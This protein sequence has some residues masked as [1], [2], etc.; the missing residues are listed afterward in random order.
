MKTLRYLFLSALC[1]ALPL[2]AQDLV[3]KVGWLPYWGG[4]D[5]VTV[6]GDNAYVINDYGLLSFD[7]S[8]PANPEMIGQFYIEESHYN[9]RGMQVVGEV[10]NVYMDEFF[11]FD[12]SDPTNPR[13]L[14]A[15]EPNFGAIQ[16][17]NYI[18]SIGSNTIRI[19]DVSDQ[20]EPE[21][22]V[23]DGF[24]FHAAR[25]TLLHA[26]SLLVTIRDVTGLQNIG[27]EYY[28]HIRSS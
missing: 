16:V 8:D 13:L 4:F 23:R 27:I 2:T 22:F 20:D 3:E 1:S 14:P 5:H 26:D 12:I 21:H 9:F 19:I 6:D 17:G 15:L 25:F 7:V 11:R 28:I 18:Y 10:L 24:D